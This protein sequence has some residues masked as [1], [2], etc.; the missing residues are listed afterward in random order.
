MI[1]V[2]YAKHAWKTAWAIMEKRW[3]TPFVYIALKRN[4][5]KL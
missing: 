5:S 3:K 4:L 1:N 2:T